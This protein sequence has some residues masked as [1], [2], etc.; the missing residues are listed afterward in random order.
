MDEYAKVWLEYVFPVYLIAIVIMIIVMACYISWA[1]RA[2]QSNGVPVLATLLF[3][4]YTKLLRNAS[5]SLFY[6]VGIIHLPSMK[7]EQVW[8]L[9]ANVEYFGLKFTILFITSLLIFFLIVIPFTLIMLFTKTFLRLKHVAKF[10]PM[11]DAYQSP[12]VNPFRFWLGYRLL[13]RAF[14]FS[15]SALDTENVL[16]INSITLSGLAIMQGYFRPYN[17]FY[18]N[19]WDLSFL[20]NLATLFAV[21]QYFGGANDI[22]VT[23][24]VGIS[25]VKFGALICYHVIKAFGRQGKKQIGKSKMLHK[26]N[27]PLHMINTSLVTSSVYKHLAAI[28]QQSIKHKAAQ[29]NSNEME[30]AEMREPLVILDDDTT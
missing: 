24:L 6:N 8:A 29:R 7:T 13:I 2:V 23:V 9:D 30:Y 26:M 4:S 15:I 14:L 16:L 18:C 21:S 12:F 11:L 3:L 25:F 22:M 5:I 20:L 19:L 17:N 28:P 10:K 1:Q 27:I